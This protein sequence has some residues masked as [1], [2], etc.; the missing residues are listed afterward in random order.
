MER[1]NDIQLI[2]D[3]LAGDDNAFTALVEKHQ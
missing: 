2:Q 3:T 1:E